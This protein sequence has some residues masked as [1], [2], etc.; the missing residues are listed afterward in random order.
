MVYTMEFPIPLINYLWLD[1][2]TETTHSCVIGVCA[3]MC[4]CWIDVVEFA[5]LTNSVIYINKRYE[6]H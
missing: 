2:C 1:N 3:F 5:I 6:L 4:D